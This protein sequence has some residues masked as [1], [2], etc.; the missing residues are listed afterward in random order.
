MKALA[1]QPLSVPANQKEHKMRTIIGLALLAVIFA[2]PAHAAE[3]DG[4]QNRVFT[5]WRTDVVRNNP[6]N[7]LERIMDNTDVQEFVA[8][9]N[10]SPPKSQKTASAIAVYYMP[11]T[12][13]MLVVWID[14]EGCIENTEQIPTS[15]ME[16]LLKGR[17]F[18]PQGS[19][20]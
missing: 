15:V 19:Q 16:S 5:N 1:P 17:P 11:P 7:L 3:C 8:A 20:S 4:D 12:P 18:Y 6:P 13:M 9:Y 2:L 14:A 10:E